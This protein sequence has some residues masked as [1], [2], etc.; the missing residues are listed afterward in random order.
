[1]RNCRGGIG[2]RK[3]N[4]P[5]L[6][7]LKKKYICSNFGK[8]VHIPPENPSDGIQFGQVMSL[9][10]KFS[11]KKKRKKNQHVFKKIFNPIY[12]SL[13]SPSLSYIINHY[14]VPKPTKKRKPLLEAEME[15]EEG[16][17]KQEEEEERKQEDR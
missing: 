14:K 15:E 10:F 9:M 7:M 16:K 1:M 5:P 17:E 8:N 11:L 13:Y 6:K 12:C 4:L 2:T 3:G